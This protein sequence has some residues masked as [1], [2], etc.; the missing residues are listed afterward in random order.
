[1]A[2][3]IINR[4]PIIRRQPIK[5]R[6]PDTTRP[7]FPRRKELTAK[8]EILPVKGESKPSQRD[9]E[10]RKSQTSELFSPKRSWRL[11]V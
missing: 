10:K 11:P 4:Q 5:A 2:H 6:N 8:G 3:Q 9:R 7:L 1:M